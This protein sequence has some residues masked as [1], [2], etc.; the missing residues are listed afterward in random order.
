VDDDLWIE[1][2]HE[3][4]P[5][6]PR[7][8]E[9]AAAL[10]RVFD[11]N[12]ERVF[13]SRQ[14]EVLHEGQWFH[15]VTNRALR[16]LIARGVVRSEVRR[17]AFGGSVHLMWHRSHR[18]YR[19]DA[20]AVVRLVEEYADPNIGGA[21]GLQG[22]VMVLEG[23]ARKQFVMHGRNTQTFGDRTWAKSAH[24]LDFIFE[25]D[26]VAYGIEVKNTL[27]YMEYAEL[28]LKIE[29][30]N[31]LGLRP[32]FAVRMLPKSWAKEVI[33]A[34]GFA[35]ILKYQLYPWAHRDLAKRVRN[36]LGLPVDAPRALEDGTMERFVRAR[37]A[38]VICR[39]D[40]HEAS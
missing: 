7:Q 38:V 2:E 40:S 8:E 34:G 29:M 36:D 5:P 10:E 13:F 19:R 28:K 3:A 4:R 31:E 23:F 14:L 37:A 12:R 6:D 16:H 20:A 26:Q 33:D 15:W 32:L 21:L 11:E 27:G 24:D 9:A 25:R 35:L 22:E 1:D 30:C 17:L 18:Y 39:D